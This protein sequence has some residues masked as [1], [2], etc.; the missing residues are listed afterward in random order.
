MATGG[1]MVTGG[2]QATGGAIATGGAPPTGGVAATGGTL[3][4]SAPGTGGFGGAP[5]CVGASDGWKACAG[6]GCSVCNELLTNYPLYFAHHPA[7]SA[8]L[9]CTAGSYWA[10]SS[11]C[12]APTANDQLGGPECAGATDGWVGCRGSGCLV[13]SEL[14]ANYPKYIANHPNCGL[15]ESCAGTG[16]AQCSSS[17]PAPT[18]CD[19]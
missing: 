11:A 10:C 18:A 5:S 14:I 17:C 8:N 6:T 15:N 16:Y 2:A 7:C 9:N 4:C 3:T 1:A 19:K 12:P 13:C